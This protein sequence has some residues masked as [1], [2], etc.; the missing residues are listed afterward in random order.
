[1][2]TTKMLAILV[3]ALPSMASGAQKLT[4]NG[5]DVNSIT[6]K[7]GQVCTVEVVSDD[8]VSYVD[9]VGFDNRVVLGTFLHLETRPE[10]GNDADVELVD[11]PTFYGYSV[12]AAGMAPPPSPGVHFVFQYEA[13]QL[14][15]TD[16]KLYATLPDSVHITVIPREKGTAFTYQGRLIDVNVPADGLYDFQFKLYDSPDVN[17]G[18]QLGSTIAI[19]ALDVIDGYFTVELDFCPPLPA[20]CNIFDGDSRWLEIGVQPAGGGS[21]TTLSPRQKV[22]PT[23]YAIYAQNVGVAPNGCSCNGTVNYI[24]KFTG[25]NTI[26]D[27]VIYES[28]GNVGIG[29]TNPAEVL[30]VNGAVK[31]GDTINTNAGTIRW[32]GTD[33]EGYD[34]TKWISLTYGSGAG[35]Q[36]AI[37][38]GFELTYNS[39]ADVYVEPGTLFHG[40][41]AINKTARTNLTLATAADWW[42]G[43]VDSYSG[44]AGWCYIGV[45]SSGDIKF[46]GDNPPDKADTAGNTD[47]TKLYW[48][49]GSNY[50]RVIGSIRVNTSDQI[51]ARWF[52]RGNLI[53]WDVPINITTTVSDGWSSA[54]SCSSAIPS[55][56]TMGLF[57]LSSRAGPSGRAVTWIR[58]NGSTWATNVA[59]G[60]GTYTYVTDYYHGGQ[61]LCFTDSSQQINYRNWN[62]NVATRIDVEGYYL[63]IR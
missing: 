45:N 16:L 39:T 52:Q 14:G 19:N 37:V 60:I 10:A 47:G 12:T 29:T 17:L 30:H 38:R 15:E 7:V 50:W 49:D 26:G 54:T 25:P 61:R 27:S 1:M 59:N 35:M 28:G 46:S 51:A 43:N 3:L 40:N 8:S 62:D 11:L 44:G 32:T 57:G 63:N 58:P 42:D 36:D 20:E 48:Y 23:P 55:I 53:M 5:Q 4:V 9:Y 31:L 34:G 13:Q 33:F 2:K 56:S 24:A 21:F 18:T 41:T 6:V 22:T